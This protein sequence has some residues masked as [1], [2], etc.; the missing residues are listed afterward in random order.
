MSGDEQS[1]FINPFTDDMIDIVQFLSDMT[2]HLH[3]ITLHK[4]RVSIAMSF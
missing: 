3:Y 2:L 4:M 1:G